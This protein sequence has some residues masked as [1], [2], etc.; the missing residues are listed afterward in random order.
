MWEQRC[1]QQRSVTVEDLTQVPGRMYCIMCYCI[2]Y[3][4]KSPIYHAATL[5]DKSTAA[6]LLLVASRRIMCWRLCLSEP[7]WPEGAFDSSKCIGL[8]E[9][10]SLTDT[11]VILPGSASKL[12]FTDSAFAEQSA[13]L[14][15]LVI[16]RSLLD[17]P[18]D[19]SDWSR[20][21]RDLQLYP[22]CYI[23]GSISVVHHRG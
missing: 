9:N 13:A 21:S 18:I 5:Q 10:R 4:A 16:Y 6:L 2:Q 7:V 22:L 19:R 11:G 8:Q 12:C 1:W 20:A 23:T 15:L 3:A 17:S 14:S